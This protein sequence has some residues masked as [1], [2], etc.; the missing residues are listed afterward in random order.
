VRELAQLG[1]RLLGVVERLGQQGEGILLLVLEGAV[2]QLQ[3]DDRV[4]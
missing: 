4:D 3:R 2:G 1:R